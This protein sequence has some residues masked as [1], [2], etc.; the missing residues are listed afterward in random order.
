M[1]LHSEMVLLDYLVRQREKCR[2]NRQ[3]EGLGSLEVDN[4]IK[5]G[6]LLYRK[7]GWIGPVQNLVHIKADAPDVCEGIRRIRHE[8]SGIDKSS[9][10]VDR[11]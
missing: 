7:I 1:T 3:P 4:E 2:G 10:L 8:S 6:R 9:I 11:W 5:F